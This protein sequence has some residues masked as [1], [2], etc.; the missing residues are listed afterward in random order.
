M[1]KQSRFTSQQRLRDKTE[2]DNVRSGGKKK[3]TP[4]FIAYIKHSSTCAR[5][6]VIVSKS[7]AKNASERNRIKRQVRETFRTRVPEETP[8]EVLIIAKRSSALTANSELRQCLE[9]LLHTVLDQ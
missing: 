6:G 3:H 7:T 4:F 5:L 9:T 1:R 2:F 8:I